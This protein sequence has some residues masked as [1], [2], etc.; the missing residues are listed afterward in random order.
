MNNASTQQSAGQWMPLAPK[1]ANDNVT[2]MFLALTLFLIAG[3]VVYLPAWLI[4]TRI[5]DGAAVWTKPQKFNVSLA[6][7]FFTLAV[8][9]KQLPREI[10]AGR[11]MTIFTYLAAGGLVFEFVYVAMQA[12]RGRRSHFNFETSFEALMYAGMG[13]AA[14]FLI[15]VAAAMAVQIWR[16]GD[17]SPE[18]RG[19]R[20]G[21]MLGLS[22]CFITTLIFAQYMSTYGRYVGGELG[23]TGAVV[24]FFGWSREFGDLRPAHFVSLHLMQT[25]P[26]AGYLADRFKWP[27]I[28]VVLVVGGVQLALAIALFAQ[29]LSGKPFWPV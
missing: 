18:T 22:L 11:A 16:K 6:L 20:W 2:R 26:L 4:D 29:A 5:L 9:A 14:V 23:Q 1:F 8:L 28:P 21:T 24:P 25:L 17:R 15:A 3:F 27:A 12:A 19:L 10:R 13:I 7:H